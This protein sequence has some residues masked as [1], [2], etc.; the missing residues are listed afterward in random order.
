MLNWSQPVSD[1]DPRKSFLEH[2]DQLQRSTVMNA[3]LYSVRNGTSMFEQAVIDDVLE[4]AAD[5]AMQAQH[6]R[7]MDTYQKMMFL[8]RMIATHHD[9]AIDLAKYAFWY[10]SQT[11][12]EKAKIKTQ[13]RFDGITSWMTTQQPTAK[14]TAFL[15]RLGHVG[16]IGDRAQASAL[17]DQLR[18][19]RADHD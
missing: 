3:F 16:P 11:D 13:K 14:Q 5:K 18:K 7:N 15:A 17:I 9:E 1:S 19:S 6:Y 12:A 2:F 4:R 10:E 8:R